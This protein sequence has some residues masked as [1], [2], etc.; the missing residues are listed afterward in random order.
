MQ[1]CDA[2]T[3]CH[4]C[5]HAVGFSIGLSACQH[6]NACTRQHLMVDSVKV[7]SPDVYHVLGALKEQK[8]QLIWRIFFDSERTP[9]VNLDTCPNQPM[10]NFMSVNPMTKSLHRALI[11]AGSL[12]LLAN[13]ANAQDSRPDTPTKVSGA[14]VISVEEGKKLL[15]GKAAFFDVRSAINYGKGHVP[16]ATA[17]PYKGTS[18]DVENFDQSKDSL[19]VS[20]LPADKASNIVIYSDGP[21]GW[22]SYKAVVLAV[23]AGY[24]KVHYMRG[25]YA[26]WQSKGLPI[27]Q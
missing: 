20:K 13:L 10:E 3:L 9:V 17:L 14:K 19:D 1:A 6:N 16:G 24:S 8:G 7:D 12:S 4:A 26:E 27:A 23:K 11:I 18:D 22:K 5:A 21:K 25:G 2:P 15:D